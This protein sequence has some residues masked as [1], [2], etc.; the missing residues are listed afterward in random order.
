MN[1]I[2]MTSL[3]GTFAA[4]AL[5]VGAGG[6]AFA[7]TAAPTPTPKTTRTLESVQAAAK[8]ATDKREIALSA[9]I[10]KL[11]AAKAI[12]ASDKS[13]L[14]DRLNADLAG[15]K[16]IESKIAAD[17][18]LAAAS[19]DFKTIFTTY[20][21]F[22][23]AIPQARIASVVD[24]VTSIDIP[25]LTDSQTRLATGLA[26][27]DALKS[28]AALQSTLA[29]MKTQVDAANTQ[30]DGVSGKVIA[31]TPAEYNSNKAVISSVRAA[32]K[33]AESDLTQARADRKAILTALK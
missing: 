20:R 5:V 6:A 1:R 11:D 4:A 8:T 23:V 30:L 32:V 33:I 22:A 17:T 31:I 18:T 26:G 15:M 25:K 13:T 9:A 24:R 27:K 28:T 12:S 7:S 3:V 2:V 16:A 19:A 14:V 29:D 10:T 21:V